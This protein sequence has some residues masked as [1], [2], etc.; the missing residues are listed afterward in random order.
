MSW[1]NLLIRL[2]QAVIML[3]LARFVDRWGAG[4]GFQLLAG[5]MGF[6][7]MVGILTLP[8]PVQTTRKEYIHKSLITR[9][10][11]A[12]IYQWKC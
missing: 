5:L 3:F 6:L 10:S 12:L 7:G 11:H 4:L 1:L 2:V 9:T 8:H